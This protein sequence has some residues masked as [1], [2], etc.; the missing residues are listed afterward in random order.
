[1]NATQRLTAI[2]INR[3]ISRQIDD[4]HTVVGGTIHRAGMCGAGYYTVVH[5]P[6][7]DPAYIFFKNL[8]QCER[9]QQIMKNDMAK[10]SRGVCFGVGEK[11]FCAHCF[12]L[13]QNC[14]CEAND[15]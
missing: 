14:I 3:I 2:A 6:H 7:R 13:P 12:A 1:M 11:E 5:H 9:W 15:E 4:E 10:T 8:M